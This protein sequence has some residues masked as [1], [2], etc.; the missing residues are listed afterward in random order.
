[1][2]NACSIFPP[3][4]CFETGIGDPDAMVEIIW[5]R[6]PCVP[7]THFPV[8]CAVV[9]AVVA[10]AVAEFS[11]TTYEMVRLDHL[12]LSSCLYHHY[13]LPNDVETTTVGCGAILQTNV[14]TVEQ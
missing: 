9:A 12:T 5:F 4:N 6:R 11:P 3:S 13:Y 7:D 10:A 8:H 2:S 1:M 14:R